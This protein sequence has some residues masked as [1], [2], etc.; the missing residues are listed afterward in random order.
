VIQGIGWPVEPWSVR[1][2]ALDLDHLARSE[3]EAVGTESWVRSC[4][5]LDAAWRRGG[6]LSSPPASNCRARRLQSR[7]SSWLEAGM[8]VGREGGRLSAGKTSD[9]GRAILSGEGPRR[10]RHRGGGARTGKDG[11]LAGH[12]A[13]PPQAPGATAA[14]RVATAAAAGV[15][16]G[17]LAALPGSWQIGTLAGWDVAAGVYVTWSWATIWHLDPAA[18]ARLAL[19]EDP[20]RPIADALLLVAS[21]A[22]VLAVALAITASHAGG[23]GER[24]LRALLAVASVAL[25]WTVVQAVFTSRYARLYYSHPAGGIDFNQDTP[26]RYA[27]FA[28]LAFTIGM[29]FQVSDTPLQTSPLRVAVLGQ[30]LLSYLLFAVIL[31]T[32][33]NL[34]AGL[35]G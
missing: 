27:D 29:T 2:R 18:T 26:P 8:P 35:L 13:A 17:L 22:S 16:A 7:G 19:R 31:A 30:A 10:T 3:S 14:T 5:C 25:S 34:V 24:D 6:R 20:G 12:G 15:G 11:P 33:I 32:T 23:R 21:V 9:R 4:P 1:E 28:Y